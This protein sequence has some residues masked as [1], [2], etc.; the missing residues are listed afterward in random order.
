MFKENFPII[1][2]LTIGHSEA[3]KKLEQEKQQALERE[4]DKVAATEKQQIEQ[5]HQD[6]ESLYEKDPEEEWFKK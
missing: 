4:A 6:R 5:E 3:D 2:P 1:D